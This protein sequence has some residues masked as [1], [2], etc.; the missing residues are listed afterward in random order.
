MVKVKL[1][2]NWGN[3]Q[4]S[5]GATIR[6]ECFT[7]AHNNILAVNDVYLDSPA[8]EAGLQPFKDFIIGTREIAFKSIDEFAKYVEI[9]VNQEIRFYIY[10]VDQEAVREVPLTPRKDWGGQ[11]ILGCDVSFGYFN[12]IPLRRKDIE[13]MNQNQGLRNILGKLTGDSPSQELTL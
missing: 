5:L 4:N 8:H 7:D 11:G 9:N 13:N 10:N 2:K 6:Y 1:H 3:Q 12:K